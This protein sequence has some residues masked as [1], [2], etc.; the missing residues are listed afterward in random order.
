VTFL[1]QNLVSIL[2]PLIALPLL[3]HLLN[4]RFPQWRLFSSVELIK[5]SMAQRSQ[6]MKWRHWLLT[7]VRTLLV[8]AAVAAFLGPMIMRHGQPPQPTARRQVLV[9]LDHSYSMEA[10]DGSV[11]LRGRAQVEASKVLDSLGGRE[12]V[13]VLAVGRETTSAFTGWSSNTTAA[14][15]FIKALGPGRERA[16]FHHAV[17]T[18]RGQLQ[19]TGG[20]PEVYVISD[21]QRTNWSDASFTD[22]PKEARIFLVNVGGGAQRENRA[23][24]NAQ[25]SGGAV[26]AGGEV[27]LHVTVANHGASL[28]SGT[29]EAVIDGGISFSTQ[30][31]VRPWSVQQTP[32]RMQAPAPGWHQVTVRLKDS[33]AMPSDDAFHLPL[34]VREQEE[35]VIASDDP[36]ETSLTLRFLDA[37]VNPYADTR[38]SMQPRRVRASALTGQELAATSKLVL[39]RVAKLGETQIRVIA[40]FLKGGGGVLY[41]L[42]GGS[43]AVNLAALAEWFSQSEAVP[44]RL[45]SRLGGEAAGGEAA[46]I[47][48]GSFDSQYLRLFR[49]TARESLAQ[50]HFYERWL[51]RPQD[52]GN[53]LLTYADGTPALAQGAAGL[54]NLMLCNFSVAEV[55]SNIARQ[56]VFPAWIQEMVAQLSGERAITPRH[57]PGEAMQTEVWAAEKTAFTGPDGRIV[58]HTTAGS[59]ERLTAVLH[60]TLPGFYSRRDEKGRLVNLLAANIAATETDLRTLDA[61]TTQQH[62]GENAKAFAV[63]AGANY[64]ELAGGMSIFH[65]FIISALA[66]L[67]V[68]SLIQ[69]RVRR[70]AA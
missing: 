38:G 59:G 9:V 12:E 3:I 22:L 10:T 53:V 58:N 6:L 70:R 33:D 25:I 39:S 66:G 36:P 61:Q 32:L 17:E 18:I 45:E 11:T 46:Q 49:G 56:R 37:A 27:T 29:V 1:H 2:A 13:N 68:E 51:A 50:L 41:F 7:L 67:L 23:I 4:R 40:D 42:D 64:A 26:L 47:A 14:R 8:A 48:K 62:A 55:A 44:L 63:E 28:M 16:D 21:F 52:R 57:E 65:W 5:R 35:V 24:T 20:A 31:S 15:A 34:K 19:N 54:G 30:V 69:M 43:D 60:A